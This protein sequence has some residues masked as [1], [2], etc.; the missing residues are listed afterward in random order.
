[1]EFATD[2]STMGIIITSSTMGFV[3]KFFTMDPQMNIQHGFP[4]ETRHETTRTS[5]ERVSAEVSM[6]NPTNMAR[7][8]SPEFGLAN[9]ASTE[10]ISRPR[11]VGGLFNIWGTKRGPNLNESH[12]SDSN[13]ED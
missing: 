6:P 1:M 13:N 2:C 8:V 5:P 12:Q 3:A 11:K 10:Q 4:K 9:Y 7:G